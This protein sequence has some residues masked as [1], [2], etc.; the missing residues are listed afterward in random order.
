MAHTCSSSAVLCV[1]TREQ[2]TTLRSPLGL[3]L[4]LLARLE[5]VEHIGNVPWP[6]RRF[7]VV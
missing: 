4:E 5:L 7:R 2:V 3:S 1:V 6:G